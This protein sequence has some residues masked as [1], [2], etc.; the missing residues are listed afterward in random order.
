M[1]ASLTI[2]NIVLIEQLKIDFKNGL[3]ALT[4]ETGAGKSI[5]LDSLGLT[6][7]AR[8]N[9]SL[10]RKDAEKAV[11]TSVFELGL[12]HPVMKFLSD[13]DLDIEPILVFKRTLTRAGVSKAYINDQIISLGLMKSAAI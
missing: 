2:K 1:L 13:N 7:G 3:C 11:V 12:D 10:I 8:S 9:T 6:L 5:L 4:G